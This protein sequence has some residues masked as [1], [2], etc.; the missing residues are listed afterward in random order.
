MARFFIE[1]PIFA[2][3]ISIMILVAGTI[4]GLSLPIAQYPQI[5]P[6]TVSVS[7]A[8]TG[9][10]A[11]VINQTVAQVLEEQVNGVQGM[12]YMSSNSDDSGAYS[13]E[14]VFDLGV[15]GD[16]AA[17]KVQNSIAQANASLPSEVTAAGVTTRKASS[18]M[19]A[20]LSFYSPKG[21][22]DSMFLTNYFNVYLKDAIKR[23]NGVGDVMVLGTEPSR[24]IWINPDRMAEQGLT[25]SD[26]V[27][28]VREQNIQA[29]AGI[30]GAM[31]VPKNQEFQYTAK[32]QGRLTSVADFENI[33]VKA[34]PNG[35]FIYLKDIARVETAGKELNYSTK[36]DGANAMAVGIQLTSDANAMN[37]MKGVNEA[38]AAA[39]ANFPPDMK[40]KAVFDNTNFISESMKEVIKTFL[41]A[42]ALVMLIVFIFLQSWRATLIPMLAVP[43]SLIGT[44]GAFVLLGFSINTLT[45]F[46]MVLAI[47]LVV[48]D[49]IVVIEAVEHHIRYSKLTPVEATKRAMSEVSGPVIA[50]AFVLAAVFVPVAFIGDMVGV[51][52]RQFA[53]T[54]AVS[55]ALS[56]FVALSLTPALCA[57]LLKPYEKQTKN[58]RLGRF[59]D[60]FND[61]FDRTTSTYSQTIQSLISKAKYC[62]IFLLIIL[63]GTVYLF[64]VVP[65][66]FVPDEDQGFF[67]TAV[68]L[69]EG[70]SMNRTQAVV[71]RLDKE[72]K[73]LPGVNQAISVV[74]FDILSN[75]AKPNTAAIFVGLEPW[76]KRKDPA[77]QIDSLIGQVQNKADLFPEASIMAFNMPSLPGLGMV[78][79]F[80][81][82][83]QDMSGHSKEELDEITKKFVSAANQH[84]EVTAVYSTY[85][86]DSPGYDFEVDREKVKTL[87]ISL[88]DVFTALQVNFGGFQV[89]DFNMFNRTYKVVM[90]ADTLFRHEADMTRFI[91]VRSANGSMI[92]LN[93][94]LK[95]KL[96]T[97]PSSISRFNAARSI[98]INGSV[99]EGYSSGQA[100]AAME[101][102]AKET[103]P[104]GFNIE[105]SGQSRQEKKASSTTMQILALSLVFV[106]LCLAALYESWS[107]PYA[108]MLSVPTGIFGAFLSQ[109]AMNLQNSVYMQIGVIMLIGLAAK[110]AILIVEFAKVRVDKGMDPAKAAVEAAA[111]RLR[112]ILMTS[113]AFIIGCLPLAIASG[114]GAGARQAMGTAVVGGMT[115]ATAFGI[116]LIPVLFVVV[117]WLV[118][119]LNW[120][121]KKKEAYSI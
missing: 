53:L 95:P 10:N 60:R 26:V 80:T 27:Q 99:G 43:V 62:C 101:K 114:A 100:I 50:I 9:A 61:W 13:L 37:T 64:K 39:A 42:M 2:I 25:V 119:K 12:N 36:Q 96:T 16:I 115:I 110:N 97:G 93:T 47:G 5:Q 23:V 78:G 105:W 83:L 7:A 108:V 28:A 38:V 104:T 34:Q 113:F 49:A 91:Y 109:Y 79:G 94:L 59:F 54:I 87:G 45:L 15:D 67:V 102:L 77:A 44:F 121:K 30:I 106:F 35:A 11:E 98:Q 86:S 118:I 32:V 57:L 22:Y 81:M 88:N 107:I 117:E 75:G 18:D 72:I 71:D 111:L 84:P 14:V 90:Q 120:K 73:E 33:V 29:P 6:P 66:T 63:V 70:A 68:T 51:L 24:R 76:S 65:T 20:L 40:Y 58:S 8:Y 103:L 56:A 112:P 19:V 48:D 4:A 116:F 89:N 69:P 82:V 46:A 3:V 92:P 41:E 1:R 52:Y 31:P 21:T 85:K 17:V 74:G 55:M